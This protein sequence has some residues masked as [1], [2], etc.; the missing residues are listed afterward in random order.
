M[1]GFVRKTEVTG[2]LEKE[3]EDLKSEHD[4]K[5]KEVKRL[6]EELEELNLKKKMSEEDIKHM[7]KIDQERRD[8]EYQKKVMELEVKKNAEIERV[9]NDYRDKTEKQL[10]TQ[11]A[12]MKEMYK[13]ILGRLPDVNVRLKGTV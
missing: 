2:K 3:L 10:E 12:N 8:I 11:V 1:F 13:E 6:K 7:V 9:R 4:L 5:E